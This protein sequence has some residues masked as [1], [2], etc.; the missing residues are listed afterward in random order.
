MNE[1]FTT[2]LTPLN[3]LNLNGRIYQDNDSL[4]ECIKDFNEKPNKFGEIGHPD[5][6]RFEISLNDVSHSIEN[7]KIEDDKVIG[8]IEILETPRGKVLKELYDNGKIVFRPRSL[9]HVDYNSKIVILNTILSY[10]A[11]N[12]DEDS[13]N[14]D[15]KIKEKQYNRVY[16]EMDPYGE[17]DWE[18]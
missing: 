15:N 18:N 4:R 1:K 11:I 9:G 16:N 14:I 17:E 7:V 3:Q 5:I 13:F 6:G 10:D 12:V 2:I 8:D